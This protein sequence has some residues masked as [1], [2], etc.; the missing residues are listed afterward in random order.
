MLYENVCI[1][2]MGYVVPD[3]VVTT[4]WLERQI[5]PVYQSLGI[6]FGYI[7]RLTGIREHRWFPKDIE[8]SDG[9]AMAAEKA[10]VK[11]GV[12]RSAIQC[13]I[14]T[15][16]C[17]DY[18]EPATATIVHHKLGLPSEAMTFDIV[19]ACLGFMNGIVTIA[20]M[21]ELGQIDTGMVVAAESSREGQLLTVERLLNN[22]PEKSA[23]RDNLASFTLGSAAV[24]M[25]LRHKS[26]SQTGKRVLGGYAYGLSKGCYL[27]VAQKE[28]MRTDSATLLDVG[29]EVVGVAWERFKA[30][31]KWTNASFNKL[32]TH[33]VSEPQR[34][35]GVAETLGLPTAGLDYPTLSYLGNTGAVAAPLCMA[36]AEHDGFLNDGD[37]ATLLGVGSGVNSIILGIQW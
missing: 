9:A 32:F 13:L 35:K 16:V 21:I 3:E 36:M 8:P 25:V 17:R 2:G 30:E 27:C 20:N 24:A 10:L 31:L 28:W 15:S 33:Q 23:M 1:E 7:E 4:E 19:N 37:T 26:Q 22:P 11:A 29:A 34:R 18:I 5:T 14:N 6:P 12:D